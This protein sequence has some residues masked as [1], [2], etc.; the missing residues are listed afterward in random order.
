MSQIDANFPVDIEGRTYHVGTKLGQV[1][2]RV[3]TVGD[4]LR[5]RVISEYLDEIYFEFTS[6]RG[7]LTI[8]GSYKYVPV[9]IIAI[10]MGSSMMD[11]FVREVRHVVQGDLIIFRFGSC[12]AINKT[13]QGNIVVAT[14]SVFVYKNY[15]KFYSSTRQG[16]DIAPVLLANEECSKILIGEL[17]KHL[18]HVTIYEGLCATTDSF[19][20]SQGRTGLE[21]KDNNETLINDLLVEHP[22]AEILEM[23]VYPLYHLSDISADSSIKCVAAA[24]VFADRKRNTFLSREKATL[25]EKEAAKSFLESIIQVKVNESHR[26]SAVWPLSEVLQ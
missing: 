24:M 13:T 17:K 14:K 26:K 1:A 19:Y 11:F 18:K 22:D 2:N 20:S 12:G 7:F 10:G 16:Y 5:A 15:N 25:L 8:T 9:S 23:E 3:I 21:F 4:P 6:K